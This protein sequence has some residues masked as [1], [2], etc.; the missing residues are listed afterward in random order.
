MRIIK[1]FL[2]FNPVSISTFVILIVLVMFST[3]VEIFELFELKTYDERLLWRGVREPS[4]YVVGAVLDEKSLDREGV[5]PWPRQKIAALIDKL[6]DDGAKVIGFDIFFTEPSKS[7][8]LEII[9]QVEKKLNEL[10][11]KDPELMDYLEKGKQRTDSDAVFAESIR[12]SKAKVVLPYFW[13]LSQRSLGYEISPEEHEKR[14]QSLSNS[15][16]SLTK[17]DSSSDGF[18]PFDNAEI[19]PYA[20]EVNLEILTEAAAGTG[21]INPEIPLDGVIRRMPMAVKFKDEV[22]TAFSLQC[23]WQFLDR[24][25]LILDIGAG[26][27]IEGV[28][29]GPIFIPTDEDGKI[30]VNYMGPSGS[31]PHYPITDILNDN[32]EKGT[33]EGKIVIVGST[34]EGAHDMRNTPFDPNQPGFEIHATVIDNIIREDFIRKSQLARAYD[35][36]AIIILGVLIA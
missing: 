15:V 24:P 4:P 7:E 14:Y 36:L 20:P 1:P 23:A 10:N 35:A 26:Y 19:K 6:S 29:L 33:F 16:Y 13:H 34:A 12:N 5:W 28:N 2:S 18:D 32:F 3:G 11:I 25:N 17:W 30:L 27:G 8:N 22:F 21:Y 9:N 31:V